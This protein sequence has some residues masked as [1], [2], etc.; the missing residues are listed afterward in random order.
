MFEQFKIGAMI[1]LLVAP[2]VT[3]A[4]GEISKASAVKA[5]ELRVTKQQRL[6]CDGRVALVSSRINEDAAKA[7]EAARS[8]SSG[9]GPTPIEQAER[10][11]LCD[12][13]PYC[14]ERK[15]KKK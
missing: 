1:L 13:D 11:L 15:V 10:Q 9:I 6:V 2:I 5:A 3:W 12:L 14:R 7:I 4:Y 8:A